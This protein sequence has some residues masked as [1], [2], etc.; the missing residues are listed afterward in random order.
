MRYYRIPSL[1]TYVSLELVNLGIDATP[2]KQLT[3]RPPPR[4]SIA[5]SSLCLFAARLL[6]KLHLE[7]VDE[8]VHIL[9]FLLNRLL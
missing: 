6:L 3:D 5:L 8:V 1:H 4:Q 2:G 7:H 9:L